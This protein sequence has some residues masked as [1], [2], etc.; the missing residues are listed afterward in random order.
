M[1]LRIKHSISLSHS[2][3]KWPAPTCFTAPTFRTALA[4]Q[5]G[6]EQVLN[7]AR[8]I[9]SMPPFGNLRGWQFPWNLTHT[10]PVYILHSFS[11]IICVIRFEAKSTSHTGLLTTG[12]HNHCPCGLVTGHAMINCPSGP[13]LCKTSPAASTNFHQLVFLPIHETFLMQP[14][15][16]SLS[17]RFPLNFYKW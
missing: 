13:S 2:K 4:H 12:P 10:K 14:L 16:A 5:P 17:S 1:L 15:Q 9:K 7:A 3:W 8:A 11:C 6:A